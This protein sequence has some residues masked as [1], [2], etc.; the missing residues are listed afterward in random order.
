V[1]AIGEIVLVVIGILIALAINNWK[2]NKTE[3]A[4]LNRIISIIKTDLKSDLKQTT[5]AIET[6]KPQQ[7]LT[8]KILYNPRFKDSIRACEECRYL[9]TGSYITEFNTKGYE[10]LSNN[11][12]DLKTK[13]KYVD[14][15]LSFYDKY[16]KADFEFKN[17]L[18]IE[19][20]VDYMKYLRDNHD[21]YSDYFTGICNDDCLDYFESSNYRNRLTYYGLFFDDFLLDIELYKA[22]LE[23]TIGFLNYENE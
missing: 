12:T 2:E 23:K 4:E 8:Y 5:E 10:L 19:D 13:N 21:W 11:T 18:M 15:I 9:L 7:N 16:S 17:K 3:Q 22:D 20:V 1:Y 14:S 6:L